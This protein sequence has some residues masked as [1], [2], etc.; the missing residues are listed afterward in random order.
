MKIGGKFGGVVLKTKV[1][2][3]K[4]FVLCALCAPGLFSCDFNFGK[5]DAEE[6]M[7]PV[8]GKLISWDVV[9]EAIRDGLTGTE[10]SGDWKDCLRYDDNPWNKAIGPEYIERAFLAARNADANVKLFYNDYSLNSANKAQ[11]VYNMVNDINQRYPNVKGRPLIDGIGMQSHHQL[12][13]SPSTVEISIELFASLGVDIAISEMDIE[14][15]GGAWNTT[16]AQEQADQY[17]AMFAVFKNHA[18]NISRVTFWGLDDAKSW[19]TGLHATLLNADLS[20][21][22]AFYALALNSGG[23]GWT[24]QTAPSLYGVYKS[25]FLLG[26]V[27]SPGD[28][29][30]NRFNLLNRHYNSATAE[31]DMKPDYLAPSSKPSGSN[32]AYKWAN[33]DK[34]VNAV[35]A[36]GMKMHGHTLIWHNQTPAWLTSGTKETVLA[37]LEKY[38]TDVVTH[39]K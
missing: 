8:Q 33:A 35:N 26:N 12:S 17:T 20:P 36:A 11:A 7:P 1:L 2:V 38:V 3:L 15:P 10:A 24:W 22:P 6:E 13:T 5:N 28:L 25:Y 14:V 32:W 16:L 34:L 23:S 31:N 4:F 30:T 29:G 21:K 9:N 27:V 19:K 18:S 37:N 39:F